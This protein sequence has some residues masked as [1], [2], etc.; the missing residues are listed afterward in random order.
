MFTPVINSAS[1]VIKADCRIG[2]FVH[3]RIVFIC[4]FSMYISYL[5]TIYIVIHKYLESYLVPCIFLNSSS[6]HPTI[7]E[8]WGH[9]MLM[10]MLT[11]TSDILMYTKT[12][13]AD[14]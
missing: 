11:L 14:T 2:L 3:E 13:N 1:L 7:I 9:A 8:V 5:I 12:G 4:L 6:C 10:C